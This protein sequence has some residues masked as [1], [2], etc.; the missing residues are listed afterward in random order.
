MHRN[1]HWDNQQKFPKD[2]NRKIKV[3]TGKHHYVV[4]VQKYVNGHNQELERAL[5]ITEDAAGNNLS[6]R[7]NK[8][9]V[10]GI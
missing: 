9:V 1:S 2:G 7:I 10:E 3:T 6:K 8:F 4:N 5:I